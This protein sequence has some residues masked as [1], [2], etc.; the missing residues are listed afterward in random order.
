MVQKLLLKWNKI[1][2][3]KQKNKKHNNF[4]LLCFLF[5]INYKIN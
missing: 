1:L 3:K 2:F 5:F 4:E